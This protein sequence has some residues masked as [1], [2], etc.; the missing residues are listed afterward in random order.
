MTR[1]IE[2]SIWWDEFFISC[3]LMEKCLWLG[4]V[5]RTADDQGRMTN[6]PALIRSDIFPADES[7][8]Q[9]D[10]KNAIQKFI[11]LGKLH[12]YSVNNKNLLQVTN[13]WKY[14]SNASWMSASPLPPPENWIDRIRCHTKGNEIKTV[15][16]D[17]PGGFNGHHPTG[18]SSQLPSD[19]V[20]ATLPLPS[21]EVD[22]NVEVEGEVD[23]NV[24]DEVEQSNTNGRTKA[25]NAAD[26]LT[27]KITKQDLIPLLGVKGYTQQ[28]LLDQEIH[29]SDLLAEYSRNLTRKGT[30]KIREPGSITGMNLMKHEYPADEWYKTKAW[31][32]LPIEIKETIDME[33]I[34]G[35]AYLIGLPEYEE[36]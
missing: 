26:R 19:K 18:L 7:I 6:N 34:S 24:E 8:T 28:L 14:Q 35:M 9:A 21:R 33:K 29:V 15:N 5:S 2:P 4:L 10:I 3:S 31:D 36:S 13:W 30:G 11:D 25:Q 12:S 17:R 20:V 16:W 1:T 23:V 32:I 27:D 22:V